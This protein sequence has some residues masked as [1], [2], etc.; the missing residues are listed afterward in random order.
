M[1][2]T[3]SRTKVNYVERSDKLVNNDR[4]D[5]RIDRLPLSLLS[6]KVNHGDFKLYGSVVE[7]CRTRLVASRVTD[8]AKGRSYQLKNLQFCHGFPGICAKL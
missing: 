4:D 5:C 3:I 7:S 6:R 2:K 1:C 8:E